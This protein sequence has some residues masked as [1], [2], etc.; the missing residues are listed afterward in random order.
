MEIL[1][2][3]PPTKKEYKKDPNRVYKTPERIRKATAKYNDKNYQKKIE[4]SRAYYQAHKADLIAKNS[5]NE[6]RKAYLKEYSKRR[7]IPTGGKQGVY[8][9]STKVENP[10]TTDA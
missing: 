2:V 4:Y 6:K 10:P 5:Q 8:V 7:Y 3:P 1:P 9:R